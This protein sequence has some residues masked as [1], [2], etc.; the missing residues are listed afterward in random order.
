MISPRIHLVGLGAVGA[1]YGA[2]LLEAGFDL[3]VLVDGARRERYRSTVTTVN[4]V[5]HTFPLADAADGTP[6][7]LALVAVK[8]GALG[9]AIELLR[10]SVG[11]GTVV[12]SLLNGIDSEQ[13]LADAFPQAHVLLAVSL[14]IDAVRDGR[15]V[16]Y[17]SL[18]RIFFGEPT[19]AEPYSEPVR[20]VAELFAAAGIACVIPADMTR[21]LWWK[22]LINVGVNQV[23]AVLRAPY[24]LFQEHGSPAR[25]AMLA[26]QREVIAVAEAEGV[27]LGETDIHAWLAVLDGLG[28]ASYTSMA[29]DAIAGRPTEVDIFAG[30]VCEL[31]ERHGI[32]TP[33]NRLLWQLL[34]AAERA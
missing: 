29:Q 26:A 7:D 34:K 15:D 9:E 18:G 17:T 19:N 5:D 8:A 4:G 6:A 24:R 21:E 31:G 33:V 10:P 25:D 32:P 11:P 22:F 27:A 12:L 13:V 28:P 20:R 23:S 14:G 1:G 2:K 30:R 16:R 3:R